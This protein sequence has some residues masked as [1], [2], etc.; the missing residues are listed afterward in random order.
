MSNR[1]T[2][3]TKRWPTTWPFGSPAADA[4]PLQTADAVRADDP[5]DTVPAGPAAIQAAATAAPSSPLASSPSDLAGQALA[6]ADLAVLE[7]EMLAFLAHRVAE[8]GAEGSGLGAYYAG[9]IARGQAFNDSDT[10][11]LNVLPYN[12]LEFEQI[13]EAGAGFGQLGL[14]LGILGRKVTCVEAS[15][16]RFDCMAALKLWLED[17]YPQLA[18]NVTLLHGAWPQA[19][20]EADCSRSLMV[21]VDFV[22]TG[23]G[24]IEATAIKGLK[25]FGGA[26]IDASHFVSTRLT[27]AARQTF[28]DRLAEAGIPVPSKLPP[29]KNN[30][31]SEFI[32]VTAAVG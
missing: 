31:Q 26:I 14:A 23:K 2:D 1:G 15:R 21:A 20:A 22:F 4:V 29:Y 27:P 25:P 19:L 13:V 16:A 32:F 5:A 30:R 3:V 8:L 28:Y 11:L 6:F 12:F 18:G 17:K 24:D 7:A 10:M 9:Q